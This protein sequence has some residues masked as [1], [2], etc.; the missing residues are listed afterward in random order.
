[1]TIAL[2]LTYWFTWAWLSINAQMVSPFLGPAVV[3]GGIVAFVVWMCGDAQ[4]EAS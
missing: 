2:V 3:V 4:R 1:M